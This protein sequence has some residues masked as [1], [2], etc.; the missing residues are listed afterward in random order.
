MK[1]EKEFLHRLH[2]RC[3]DLWWY[4]I[5]LFVAQRFGDVINLFVGLWIVPKYV[6]QDELGAVLPLAQ[7]VSLVGLPLG[8]ITIPFMKYLNVFAEAGAYGKVKSLLRDVFIWTGVLSAFILVIAYFL[9]PLLFERVRVASGS[10]GFL[11]VSVSILGAVSCVFQSAVQGMKEFSAI[12]WFNVLAAP[13]RLILM[14]LF[15]PFRA[16]SGYFVG[17]GASPGVT[18]LGSLWVLRKKLGR[19]VKAEPYLKSDGLA[20]LRYTLPIAAL[21]AVSV[22]TASVDSLIIRQR[23]SNFESAGYY[24]VTRFSDIASYLGTVFIVFLFPIVS[25][26]IARSENP[27]D[28][29]IKTLVG[30]MGSGMVISVVLHFW[31]VHILMLHEVWSSYVSLAPYLFWLCV[32]NV[33]LMG[34]TAFSTYECARGRFRFLWYLL[35]IVIAKSGGL[36]LLTGYANFDGMLPGSWMSFLVE[37]NPNRLIFI[38][39]GFL[40]FQMLLFVLFFLDVFGGKNISNGAVCKMVEG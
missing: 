11:I 40:F 17:Q 19:D 6:P 34:N 28:I 26:R 30:S 33:F 1:M 22:V 29:L 20:M 23:L 12:V 4:T 24:V 37:F 2:K 16:I 35:P 27:R 15:M 39:T 36:Y 3:G 32:L 7:F 31:G 5:L 10:L 9:L 25:S 21:T 13:L 14:L 38:I 18:V 8:I